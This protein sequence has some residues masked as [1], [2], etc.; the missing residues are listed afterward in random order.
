M[1]KCFS[2]TG[3]PLAFG[4]ATILLTAGSMVSPAQA[5]PRDRCNDYANE[6]ISMDQR[7]RQARCNGWKSHSNYQNHYKWC[8]GKSPSAAQTALSAWGTR[9]QGCQFAA[10]GSPAA[11]GQVGRP[12]A[13]ARPA[14][15]GDAS[16]RRVCTSFG[17]AAATYE[18]NAMAQGCRIQG[19]NHTQFNGNQGAAFNWCMGTSD[20]SFRGRSPQAAGHKA[21]LERHC[22]TQL[23]RPV[24]L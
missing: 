19:A 21:A 16:R 2:V 17:L 15:A 10:S 13:A 23:R 12:V 4:V 3:L 11:Q 14:P 22:G 5:Q 8:Q 18:R 24:R 20:A 7:A 1:R 9:L 6:M